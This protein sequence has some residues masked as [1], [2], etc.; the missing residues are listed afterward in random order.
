MNKA[1]FI[2]YDLLMR[3]RKNAEENVHQTIEHEVKSEFH[4]LTSWDRRLVKVSNTVELKQVTIKQG[5][6]HDSISQLD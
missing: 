1:A 2:N 6:I 3:E 4:N 5:R